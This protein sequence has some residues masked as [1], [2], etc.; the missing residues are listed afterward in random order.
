MVISCKNVYQ[1]EV[2][3]PQFGRPDGKVVDGADVIITAMAVH[4]C[5][6]NLAKIY[7]KLGR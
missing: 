3:D 4:H 1:F 2:S 7:C 5:F 6:S